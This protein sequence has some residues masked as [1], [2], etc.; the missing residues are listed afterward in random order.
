MCAV[1]VRA[2]TAALPTGGA[3]PEPCDGDG[4]LAT[5]SDAL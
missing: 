1:I 4:Q 3:T 5:G 2:P